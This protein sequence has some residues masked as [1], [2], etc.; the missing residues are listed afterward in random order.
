MLFIQPM[1]RRRKTL[2]SQGND[3]TNNGNNQ[4]NSSHA[5][6]NLNR[7]INIRLRGRNNRLSRRL[8]TVHVLAIPLMNKATT[9]AEIKAR[10]NAENSGDCKVLE[11]KSSK[12]SAGEGTIS[13]VAKRPETLAIS[14]IQ[15]HETS[16]NRE[17]EGLRLLSDQKES[18]R[19][20]NQ[21]NQSKSP[22]RWPE[23]S[24][25]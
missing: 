16:E 6:A 10:T 12:N 20:K 7:I 24:P 23:N 5:P 11:R 17:N 14:T 8:K 3:E 21:S 4:N 1:S 15:A 22:Q 13:I 18:Y 19:S 2:I 9:T 25:N